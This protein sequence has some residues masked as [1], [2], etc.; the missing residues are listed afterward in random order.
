MPRL[1]QAAKLVGARSDSTFATNAFHQPTPRGK[2][3]DLVERP[4]DRLGDGL[5]SEDLF[6]GRDLLSIDDH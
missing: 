6:R 4:V 2:T 1:A 3:N 5:R